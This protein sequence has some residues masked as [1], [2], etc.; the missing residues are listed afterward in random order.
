MP[1]RRKREREASESESDERDGQCSSSDDSENEEEDCFTAVAEGDLEMLKRLHESGR[2]DLQVGDEEEGDR[3][4]GVACRFGHLEMAQWICEQGVP[5]DSQNNIG[6]TALHEASLHGHLPV[7]EW[8]LSKL[9]ASAVAEA[10][11]DGMLPVS[12]AA[13]HGH[14][15]VVER[16]VAAGSSLSVVNQ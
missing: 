8:L 1:S 14:T 5:I 13:L 4:F 10:T 15:L 12:Y 3:P 16:L 7:V 11:R 9:P 6:D 2:V